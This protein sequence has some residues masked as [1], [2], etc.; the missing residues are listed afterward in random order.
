MSGLNSPS[1]RQAAGLRLPVVIPAR[2]E[3]EVIGQALSS[4][5]AQAYDGPLH[6]V[7]VDDHSTDGTAMLARAAAE[8][9][10]RTANL[11]VM[12]APTL[13]PGWSGKIAAQVAGV[14]RAAGEMPQAKWF[15]LT[16]ADIA[17]GAGMLKR[18]VAKAENEDRHLVS[19]MV[20]LKAG[21][22]AAKLL[23]PAFVFFFQ[24]LYQGKIWHL[25]EIVFGTNL[26]ISQI[27]LQH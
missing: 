4:L 12:S 20:L 5:F 3:A 23:I 21:G 19:L 17:H 6:I 13:K 1:G 15:L 18:L 2:D 24:K 10:G 26:N 8:K 14:T 7:L 16:D 11:T 27:D 22:F 25:L 9:S